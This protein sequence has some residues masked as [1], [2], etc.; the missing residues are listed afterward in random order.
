M[1]ELI[2]HQGRR[3][4]WDATTKADKHDG[5][6]QRERS[7]NPYHTNRWT[8][9][10]RA[11]RAEHPRCA[12]CKAKGITKAAEVVDHIIPYPICEDFYDRSNLQSLCEA[13]NRAKGN[14]DRKLIQQWKKTH[15]NQQ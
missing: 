8:R 7:A 13:C 4:A 1:P 14:R 11:F 12:E 10:S 3:L 5:S 2:T 6:Y 15:N 9:L